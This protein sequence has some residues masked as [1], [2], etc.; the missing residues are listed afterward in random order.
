MDRSFSTRVEELVIQ[1]AEPLH[2][3]L[4]D[5]SYNFTIF[6]V[7]V[8]RYLPSSVGIVKK[9]RGKLIFIKE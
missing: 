6:H 4:H 1:K 9:E 5:T 8:Y 2:I 7:G 3:L